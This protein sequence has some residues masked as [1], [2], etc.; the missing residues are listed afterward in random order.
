[1]SEM[2]HRKAPFV[3]VLKYDIGTQEQQRVYLVGYEMMEKKL[4]LEGKIVLPILVSLI[5]IKKERE[6]DPELGER[7]RPIIKA[8]KKKIG[9]S[10]V[11]YFPNYEYTND[12]ID[13]LKQYARLHNKKI[14][15][16]N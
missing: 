11:V 6:E 16:Y 3:T 14:L 15:T 10:K 8:N 9:L 4:S 13:Q 7:A 2:E 5:Q 1:M 12:A